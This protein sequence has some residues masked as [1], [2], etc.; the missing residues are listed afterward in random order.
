MFVKTDPY[1]NEPNEGDLSVARACRNAEI[2]IGC[3]SCLVN[4]LTLPAQVT[5]CAELPFTVA[6]AATD[7]A[8]QWRMMPR[9]LSLAHRTV[10]ARSRQPK[11][12]R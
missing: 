12:L 10:L 3:N 6:P 4:F 9:R 1:V 11:L 7:M 5:R 2:V 8:P